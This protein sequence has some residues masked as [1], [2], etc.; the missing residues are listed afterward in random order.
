[1]AIY[2]YNVEN[3]YRRKKESRRTG[4]GR[5][6][7]SCCVEE[8]RNVDVSDPAVRVSPVHKVD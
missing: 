3:G 5:W 2:E 6:D 7:V 8:D 1:M 4:I